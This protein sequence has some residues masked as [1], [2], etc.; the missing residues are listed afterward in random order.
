MNES[1]LITGGARRLGFAMARKSLDMGYDVI[2]HYRSGRRQAEYW[3]RKHPECCPRVTFIRS[4]LTDHP[5]RLFDAAYSI[6]RKL[7]G[8]VNNASVFTP[9]DISNAAHYRKT[10]ETNCMVPLKLAIAFRSRIKKGWI[11]NITDAHVRPASRKWRNYRISKRVL[12]R[13]T[14]RL[15]LALAPRIRVN[16]IAPGAMLPA[17][18][19]DKSEFTKLARQIPLERTGDIGSLLKAYEYL[20]TAEYVTGQTLYVDGGWHL[21]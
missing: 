19:S 1:I 14:Y 17:R 5:E 2:L 11:I 15:A 13:L 4:E 8:L 6:S 9:G 21:A 16:A 3:L 18:G 7:V 20:V 10:L 12:Q